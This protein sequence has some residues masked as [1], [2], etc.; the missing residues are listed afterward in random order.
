MTAPIIF[1]LSPT[2]QS[3][4]FAIGYNQF[5]KPSLVDKSWLTR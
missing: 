1:E 3:L 5:P 4:P 2:C